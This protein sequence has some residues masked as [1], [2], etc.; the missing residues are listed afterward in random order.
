LI[1]AVA[2]HPNGDLA[3]LDSDGRLYRLYADRGVAELGRTDP[4]AVGMAWVDDNVQVVRASG[5]VVSFGSRGRQ[6]VSAVLGP[7]NNVQFQRRLVLA[8]LVDQSWHFVYLQV[9]HRPGPE[10]PL[11]AEILC[12]RLGGTP[13]SCGSL[14]LGEQSYLLHGGQF[15]WVNL[16]LERSIGNLTSIPPTTTQVYEHGSL[17]WSAIADPPI[18]ATGPQVRFDPFAAASFAFREQ[19]LTWL[20][21]WRGPGQQRSAVRIAKG[22]WL[23]LNQ[24]RQGLSLRYSRGRA[25]PLVVNDR[26]LDANAAVYPATDEGYWLLGRYGSYFKLTT[27]LTP[28]SART[29]TARFAQIFANFDRFAAYDE[30]YGGFNWL[31]RAAVLFVLAF[32]PVGLLL[33]WMYRKIQGPQRTRGLKGRRKKGRPRR[34]LVAL[35]AASYLVLGAAA[36]YWFWRAIESF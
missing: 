32:F 28:A 23:L 14:A 1:R 26:W 12:V 24:T 2:K 20:P 19:K 5:D 4:Q 29:L 18:A 21:R 16:P 36:F 35:V 8:Y 17:G 9:Q 15:S 13:R 33:A 34:D 30:F 25:G 7:V 31:K 10:R 6:M 27:R 11:H 22:R 3:M